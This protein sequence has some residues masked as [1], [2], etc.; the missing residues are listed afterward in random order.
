MVEY[1]SSNQ[2][3]RSNLNWKSWLI[4]PAAC[5]TTCIIHQAHP[6]H[7]PSR[8]A[9]KCISKAPGKCNSIFWVW[10]GYSPNCWSVLEPPQVISD[11]EPIPVVKLALFLEVQQIAPIRENRETWGQCLQRNPVE[12]LSNDSGEDLWSFPTQ[13]L[14]WWPL[15][16]TWLRGFL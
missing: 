16:V 13:Q 9:L 14:Q 4:F 12:P 10:A 2:S 5:R 11:V 8:Y 3:K 7:Q 6:L 1:G 15:V